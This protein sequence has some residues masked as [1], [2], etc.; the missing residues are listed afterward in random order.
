MRPQKGRLPVATDVFAEAITPKPPDAGSDCTDNPR[1]GGEVAPFQRVIIVFSHYYFLTFVSF[2][3]L[4]DLSLY[5]Q[6]SV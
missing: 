6:K 4:P 2:T 3:R 5:F 1:S